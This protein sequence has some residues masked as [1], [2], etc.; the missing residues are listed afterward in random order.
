M[1]PETT[2]KPA[3]TQE[4][5][6]PKETNTTASSARLVQEGN[7]QA[8]PEAATVNT[9]DT[10][11]PTV[12]VTDNTSKPDEPKPR[13]L[14]DETLKQYADELHKAVNREN[15]R[16]ANDPD[17][18]KIF[19]LLNSLGEADRKALEQAYLNAPGNKDHRT[20]RS[21]LE[22]R[23]DGD[24]FRKAE[25][26]LNTRDGRTNDAGNLMV[27]LS[28][29]NDNRGDAE[30]RVIETFATLNKDQRAK[31]EEDFKNDYGMTVDEAL[32]RYGMSGD[33]MKVL[34]FMNKPIE[35]RTSQ[36][37]QDF[38]RFAVDKKNLDYLSIALRGDTPAAVE[39]R[40]AL[41]KDEEFTKKLVDAFKPKEEGG[42]VGFVKGVADIAAG[43]LDEIVSGIINGDLSV[44]KVLGGT[45][46]GEAFVATMNAVD[47]KEENLQLLLALDYL[48]EG[49]PSLATIAM[50]NTGSLF[51][52][53]DNKDNIKLAVDN[54]TDSERQ[55]FLRGKE[56]VGKD[57]NTLSEADKGNLAYYERL[58]KAFE[59]A[60]DDRETAVWE[61]KLLY[62][63]D[64]LQAK[65]ADTDKKNDRFS[66]I[67]NMTEEQWNAL[68]DPNKRKEFDQFL[69][70]F[71]DEGDRKRMMELIDGKAAAPDFARSQEVRRTVTELIQHNTNDGFFSTSYD[72]KKIVEGLEKMSPAEAQK[73]K[74]D[75]SFRAEIDKF[76]REKLNNQERNYAQHML[77]Q[78][79]QTG[80][81]PEQDAVGKILAN[82][83]TGADSKTQLTAIEELLTQDPE[84]RKRLGGD[85]NAL[86]P[87]EKALRQTIDSALTK[88]I[89]DSPGYQAMLRGGE[90]AAYGAS[91]Y[92]E[93]EQKNLSAAIFE[94]GRLPVDVKADLGLKNRGFYEEAAK[95][96]PEE[97]EKLFKNPNITKEERQ[98]IEKVAEQGGQMKVEDKMRSYILGDG[99]DPSE[100]KNE[101]R[102]MTGEQKQQLKEEYVRKYGSALEDDLLSKI[103]EKERQAYKNALT[104]SE[105][106]GRQDYYDNLEEWLKSRSGGGLAPDAT[107]ITVERAMTD[108]AALQQW[109]NSRFEK[110]PPS[111]MRLSS[112]NNRKRRW[113]R[114]SPPSRSP[115]QLWRRHPSPA[116]PAWRLWPASRSSQAAWQ[117]LQ[118]TVPSR[119]AT[120]IG[121]R[122]LVTS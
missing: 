81:P 14:N 15:W 83:A 102:Q 84:L 28:A 1:P 44:G 10:H 93:T 65:I 39:A 53:F 103:P 70:R 58:H 107:G 99:S 31:L 3:E 6:K 121:T 22:R 60:G 67:E 94:N 61:A 90:S 95:V 59:D 2:T 4:G 105:V 87:S 62:G 46:I 78:V 73:Y 116:V 21:E 26:A 7:T 88:I 54:A 8:R 16:G 18:D 100:F 17:K 82:A 110:M 64:S 12:T 114:F 104:P 118:S 33:G 51:G 108:Q 69:S 47:A 74:D 5:D 119:A 72:G 115:Q 35:Q 13:A 30:R 41:Q 49:R 43:P 89:A 52:W 79:E 98:L 24:D 86:S 77:R 112:T 66:A 71:V 23:M 36:D 9:A 34:G 91:R 120:T 109:F 48:R 113:R 32:K 75:P 40:Q 29:I 68:K 117:K 101:L 85:V 38:A 92:L 106:D 63:K 55:A 50:N 11:L 96:S 111:K 19:Q 122:R 76:V 57:P 20:L 42:F 37:I 25:A 80:K 56:L 27:S 97:R 45:V